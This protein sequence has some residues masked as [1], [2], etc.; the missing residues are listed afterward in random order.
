M[1]DFRTEQTYPD[2]PPEGFCA[3]LHPGENLFPQF[4]FGIRMEEYDADPTKGEVPESI[5]IYKLFIWNSFP[6][7]TIQ[8]KVCLRFLCPGDKIRQGGMSRQVR[9]LFNQRNIPPESRIR[10][11]IVCDD[12]GILWIPHL[13]CRDRAEAGDG[14]VWLFSYFTL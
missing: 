11:P 1:L 9:K 12:E 6:Y 3:E 5:N 7:D 14:K 8:G 13:G 4:G 2:A 10:C